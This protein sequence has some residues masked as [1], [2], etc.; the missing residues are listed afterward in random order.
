[1]TQTAKQ[2]K[3]QKD[4]ESHSREALWPN[5]SPPQDLVFSH[6]RGSEL[7]TADGDAYLDF[8]SGIAVT[9]F[10]H[11]HP[12]LVKALNEQSEKLWH[13]SNVFRIPEGERLAQRLAE[14]SFADRIF[15][16]NSGTEAIEASIKAVR[17]YQAAIGKKERY[18]LIGFSDSF[19]GRTIAA[20]AASGNPSYVQNF[21][22]TDHGFDH[23]PWGDMD[24]L[25]AAITEHTA[26]IIIE[27]VQ[28]EGGIRP[29]TQD[30]IKHL[31]EVCDA[32]G[33]LL[34]L[35]EVQC[36]VGRTGKLFAHEIFDI[37]PD[38]L[39]SAKGLGG[40]FPLGACLV[41]EE[42]GQHMVVG[43]HGSTFGGNPLA[44]AVGNAVLDLVLEPGLLENVKKQGDVLRSEL[45]Q[46]TQD[47]PEVV[48]R[49]TGLGLMIGVKCEKPNTELMGKLRENKLLVGKAGDNMIRLLP[50]LNVSDQHV[51]QALSTIKAAVADMQ[52]Q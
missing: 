37:A 24:A 51:Q 32:N 16:A 20:V 36:G 4:Q 2:N 44:M 7:F 11:A 50:P 25:D 9:A 30:F 33:L 40:G 41:S 22:P 19:H 31:R 34:V 47:Y 17:G 3:S 39:A 48:S 29:V 8:L 13:L 42:V 21:A 28:G 14:N 43:T 26:G 38:V 49:V 23:V 35:D 5:Y 12:H 10:G 27:P 1:M 46:L 18:R 6:G 52:R 15:F 45:E